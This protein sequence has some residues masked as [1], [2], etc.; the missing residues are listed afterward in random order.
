MAGRAILLAGPPGTGK[1]PFFVKIIHLY[2]TYTVYMYHVW[3]LIWKSYS[4]GKI[5]T[6]HKEWKK[7]CIIIN[8]IIVLYNFCLSILL[9]SKLCWHYMF[10]DNPFKE[11]APWLL[12]FHSCVFWYYTCNSSLFTLLPLMLFYGFMGKES[13]ILQ[14]RKNT[15]VILLVTEDP[16]LNG[17]CIVDGFGPCCGSGPGT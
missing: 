4:F 2:T 16:R 15:N 8:S 3:C 1:V 9:C 17:F 13:L 10:V 6:G 12:K 11:P 14:C 5:F 7:C